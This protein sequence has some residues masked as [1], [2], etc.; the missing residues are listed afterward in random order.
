MTGFARPGPSLPQSGEEGGALSLSEATI[1]KR[2]PV[3]GRPEAS[4]SN[5]RR[6]RGC[7]RGGPISGVRPD[8]PAA[9]DSAQIRC[10]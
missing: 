3:N 8:S 5:R 2:K 1:V 9:P 4:T 10:A 7:S 6:R